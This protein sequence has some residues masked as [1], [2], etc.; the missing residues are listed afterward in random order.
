MDALIAEAK[1]VKLPAPPPAHG[2]VHAVGE[3]HIKEWKA[4][5]REA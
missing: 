1:L 3:D 2:G 5:R 4:R